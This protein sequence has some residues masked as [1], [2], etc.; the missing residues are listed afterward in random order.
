[1]HMHEKIP[2]HTIQY[3][4]HI[5]FTQILLEKNLCIATVVSVRMSVRPYVRRV[6]GSGPEF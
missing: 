1:M 5:V 2:K 6:R 4:C 3:S